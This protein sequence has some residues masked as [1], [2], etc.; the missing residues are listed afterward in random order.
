M[1]AYRTPARVTPDPEFV[2]PNEPLLISNANE[3]T[4]NRPG[5]IFVYVSNKG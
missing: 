1:T 2:V 4:Q 5:E 3:K